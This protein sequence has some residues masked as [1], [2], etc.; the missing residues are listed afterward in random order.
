M[1]NELNERLAIAKANVRQKDKLR[2]MLSSAQESLAKTSK[3]RKKLK[4][5]LKKEKS[6]VDALEGL[7]LTGFFHSMLGSK[8][9]RLEKERQQ[10]AAAIL[11]HEQADHMVQDLLIE[12][13]RLGDELAALEDADT[14]YEKLLL[15]KEAHLAET[16]SETAQT[17]TE[18]TQQ[19]ADLTVDEKELAEATTAGTSALTALRSVLGTLDSASNWGTLDL[20]GGGMITTMVKHSRMDDAKTQARSAQRKLLRFQEELADA[21]QRL[22]VSLEVDGFAKFADFFFDGLIADWVMQSKIDKAKMECS[23]TITKVESVIRKCQKRLKS[24]ELEVS[25]LRQSKQELIESA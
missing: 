19:I 10:L 25:K 11:K 2:S 21:D 17:L 1:L 24:V 13:Q 20:F 18:L 22:Q 12:L 8:E 15:E 16:Q 9:Q 6:D 7:S 4:A 5:N 3:N 14:T 23:W